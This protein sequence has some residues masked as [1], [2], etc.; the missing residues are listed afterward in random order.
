MKMNLATSKNIKKTING[1]LLLDKPTGITSNAA[2]QRIKRLFHA[3]KA[4]HTGSLDP[5]ASG[6]LP[7]CFGEATKFSQYLLD[8]DKRYFVKAKL[9]IRTATADKEGE[10]IAK[11][12][13]PALTKVQIDS[14]F[15][16]FRG[17]IEQI[18]SMFS[19]VK[20]KGQPLYKLARKGI[21][22][23]RKSRRIKIYELN[24]LDYEND[25]ISF[26]V[27]CS[28]G[29]YVRTIVDDFGEAIGCGAH[30]IY[31]RRSTVGHFQMEEMTSL[32]KLENT[33]EESLM[34][35]LSPLESMVGSWP[36]I[37]LERHTAF[38][39]QQGQAV[40]V[41]QAPAKGWVRLLHKNGQFIG[42]GEILS[43]G[44]VAPRR[45]V[46]TP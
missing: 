41:P 11:R 24:V 38:Y 34:K 40:M 31:L 32:E 7:I 9:G 21:E 26:E 33:E 12:E 2:L 29:T 4:G 18:P 42:V 3:K 13:V 25:I 10:I 20:Y 6:M 28:K 36:G 17:E 14:A 23:E 22:V 19:A 45:L 5:L 8:A 35:Y 37:E 46:N 15:D 30:V 16:A 44:K 1:I 39:L 43:D 27:S